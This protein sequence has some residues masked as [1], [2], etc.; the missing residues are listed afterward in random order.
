MVGQSTVAVYETLAQAE[1]AVRTLDQGRFPIKQVSIVT[2]NL[3]TEKEVHGFITA[4]DVAVQGA[5]TGAWFGGVF[6]LLM[7][8][9]FLMMPGFG[10]LVV[11]GSLAAS[12]LGAVHGAAFGAAGGGLLGALVGWGVSQ[13][14]VIKYEDHVRGGKYLL[15]AHGSAEEVARAQA[16]LQ[17][18]AA[19]ELNRHAEGSTETTATASAAAHAH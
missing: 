13:D 8:G 17:G 12:L 7:G 1:A 15:V 14:H 10:P 16:L 11:A 4:G 18:S 5:G 19:T 3:E 9:A 6:G 2:Q